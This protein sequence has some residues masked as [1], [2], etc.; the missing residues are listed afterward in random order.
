MPEQTP[1]PEVQPTKPAYERPQLEALGTW[2]VMTLQCSGGIPCDF[3][4]SPLRFLTG[5]DQA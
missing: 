5:Q 4:F 3:G 2:E 1:T